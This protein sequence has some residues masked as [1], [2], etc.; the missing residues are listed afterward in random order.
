MDW[1]VDATDPHSIT[2]L[3][4]EVDAYLRRHALAGEDIDGAVL[5]FDEVAGNVVKHAPGPAWVS[6]DWSEEKP[7]LSVH[8]LGPGLT[9][10]LLTPPPRSATDGRGL[11]IASHLT[12]TL[13][14][15]AKAAGGARV[16]AVLNVRRKPDVDHDPPVTTVDV[17][18][19]PEEARDDGMFSKESF[20]RA[21]VVQMSRTV[22]MLD[23]PNRAE[24]VVAQVGTDI[25]SR[26]EA[27]YRTAEGVS[28][29]LSPQQMGELFVR[30][31][32][33]IDGDFYVVS[34]DESKIVLGNR[35]CPFGE[36]V[37]KSPALCRMTSSVFGGIAARNAGPASVHLE[38]RI[39]VGDPECRVTVWLRRPA[40]GLE[41]GHRYAAR[42]P[43]E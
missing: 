24:E 38:E 41:P 17:L 6:L 23:G 30:L 3:R 27:A 15:A 37:K 19:A 33:A 25:G 20:L 1:Y 31:K 22:E 42:D 10:D 39:A 28:E 29:E 36:A 9:I 16:S 5:A 14:A 32:A 7:L 8:D 12:D 13:Q 21:L 4:R 34:A 26:M 11:L 43:L 40:A 2:A 35:R 18:P